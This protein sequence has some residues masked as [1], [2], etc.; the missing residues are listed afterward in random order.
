M[1]THYSTH[2]AHKQPGRLSCPHRLNHRVG[3]S[4]ENLITHYSADGGGYGSPNS[5]TSL[6]NRRGLL[7]LTVL[8]EI[9]CIFPVLRPHQL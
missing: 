7:T 2:T 8:W 1:Q 3:L 4:S 9:V 5:R 6:A